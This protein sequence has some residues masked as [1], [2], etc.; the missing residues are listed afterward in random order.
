MHLRQEDEGY[1]HDK[2]TKSRDICGQIAFGAL[3]LPL[4]SVALPNYFVGV[5][6]G[7]A[8]CTGRY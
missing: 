3:V 4:C 2:S 6:F 5:L 7:S 8:L 1:Q